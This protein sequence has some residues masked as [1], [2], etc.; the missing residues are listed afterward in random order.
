[1]TV[2]SSDVLLAV[3]ERSHRRHPIERAL[4]VLHA[5]WPGVE[6]GAWARAPVGQRDCG[7]LG[8]H[9]ALF[10]T[11]LITITRCPRCSERLESAF[12][13]SDVRVRVPAAPVAPAPRQLHAQDYAIDYRLPTSE[14]LLELVA[15]GLDTASAARE[16]LR[17][18]IV[19]A[20]KAGRAVDPITL[21]PAILAQLGEQMAAEDPEAEIHMRLTCP[22]CG[23]DWRISFD[24]VSYLWGELEEWV[25]QLLVDIHTLAGAYG[26]SERQI[27]A[28]SPVRRQLYVDMV[29]A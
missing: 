26:W 16:L 8:L 21:P 3:W 7:L 2:L 28:L 1:M 5:A 19:S 11:E 13:A 17:R 27:L 29:R 24:I 9:E 6:I 12:K 20:Q 23:H 4:A 25:H 22:S 15:R 10:G 18:C 14:D